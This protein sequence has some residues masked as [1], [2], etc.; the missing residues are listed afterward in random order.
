[1]SHYGPWHAI[2]RA[3]YARA[4]AVCY[5]T[6]LSSSRT[7][8]TLEPNR[9][10][11]RDWVLAL[12]DLKRHRRELLGVTGFWKTHQTHAKIFRRL[13]NNRRRGDIATAL[14]WITANLKIRNK[15]QRASLALT[16]DEGQGRKGPLAAYYLY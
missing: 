9:Q 10:I 1:M 8:G 13:Y 14:S 2:V 3:R 6:A 15:K 16:I 5:M 4:H 7:A 11:N 12:T